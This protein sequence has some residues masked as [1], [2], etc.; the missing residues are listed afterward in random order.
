MRILMHLTSIALMLPGLLLAAAVLALDHVAA[1][2]GL[3]AFL[4]AL[5]DVMLVMMPAAA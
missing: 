5:L 3:L 4:L 2:A 1:K